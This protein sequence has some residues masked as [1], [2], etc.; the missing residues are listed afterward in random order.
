MRMLRLSHHIGEFRVARKFPGKI[1]FCVLRCFSGE[2]MADFGLIPE[3]HLLQDG[4]GK[5]K[6]RLCQFQRGLRLFQRLACRQVYV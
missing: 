5:V 1:F 6:I 4:T 3:P 2:Q